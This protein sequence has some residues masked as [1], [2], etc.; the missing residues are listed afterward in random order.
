MNLMDKLE[1]VVLELKILQSPLLRLYQTRSD[2]T[3]TDAIVDDLAGQAYVE[4]F[5]LE[6]FQRADNAMKANKASR[7]CAVSSKRL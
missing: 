7:Y 5:G 1:Q 2:F 4:Q 6:T 3:E